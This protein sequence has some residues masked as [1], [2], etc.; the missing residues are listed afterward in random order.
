MAAALVHSSVSVG[1]A[2]VSVVPASPEQY[3]FVAV[4][5][6]G[7]KTAFLKMV[8]SGVT[9]TVTNGI[10][11]PAGASL[12]VDQDVTPILTGGISAVCAA[13]ETTTIAIQAY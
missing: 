11:L 8:P 3:Q 7:A 6:V 4:S 12:V 13:G 10:S 5:N 9:L 1:T 2:V